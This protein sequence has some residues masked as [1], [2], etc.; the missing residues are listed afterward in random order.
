MPTHA[1]TATASIGA[2]AHVVYATIA[3]YHTGHPRIVPK[4]FS[5]LVVERGGIGAGTVIRFDVTI[6]GTTTHLR[7]IVSEPEPGRVLVERNVEGNEAVST[8][9]VDPDPGGQ[10]CQVTIHTEMPVRSGLAGV[11]EKFMLTRVL[12]SIYKEELKR[13]EAA[14]QQPA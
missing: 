4:Q 12:T 2:P 6:L 8:F 13:L 1:V 3:N 11:I 10:R 5:N 7:A 14:A 9:V